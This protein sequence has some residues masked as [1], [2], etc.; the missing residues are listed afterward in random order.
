MTRNAA[1]VTLLT[2]TEYLPGTLVVES[3]LRSVGSKYPFVVMVTPAL[4]KVA[5]DVL[6][7]RGVKI[8]EIERV[9]PAEGLHTL[10]AH[11]ARF[12]DTWTKLR[13]VYC[14]YLFIFVFSFMDAMGDNTC[15]VEGSSLWNMM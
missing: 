9:D 13:C 15:L 2:R 1:Y 4:P 5:R 3:S 8:R 7:K 10:S 6:T 11:D 14:L 12:A